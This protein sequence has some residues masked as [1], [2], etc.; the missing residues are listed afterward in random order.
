MKDKKEIVQEQIFIEEAFKVAEKSNCLHRHVGAVLVKDNHILLKSYNNIPNEINICSKEGCMR[1]KEN[2]KSG[3]KVERCRVVHA[4]QQLIIDCALN[5][6][7]PQGCKV[8][9]THSPCVVCAKILANAEIKEICYA[10]DRDDDNFKSLF[11]DSKM[12]FKK[13]Y[14]GGNI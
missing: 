1:E 7:N 5:K 10:I 14:R 13:I 9:C 8:Y 3:E 11:K 6:I 4:E 2:I 12:I